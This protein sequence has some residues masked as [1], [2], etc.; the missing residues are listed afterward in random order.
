MILSDGGP[1]E[2]DSLIVATGAHHTYFGHDEWEA[3]APGLKTIEDAL[4][5][6][7]RILIAFEAAEREADP[8]RRREW[9]TFVVVGGGPTGV[10]L[11]GAIAEIARDTLRRDF[12]AINPR[13]RHDPPGRGDGAGPA[14]V[15]ARSLRVGPA[16]ARAARRDGPHGHPRDGHRRA[17]RARRRQHG[18]EGAPEEVIPARTVLWAAGVQA[19]SFA[20]RVAEATGAET[21]RNGRVIVGAGPDR[22]RPPRDLRRRRRGRAAVEGRAARR[23]ASPRAASRA[24]ATRPA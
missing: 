21:D 12:R 19:S 15:P 3:V 13:G 1:L 7:R 9:M 10:E 11:A 23:P 14:A 2:Y 6:R 22:A 4:E 20:R 16:P 5:I 24:G 8:D 17:V 18:G